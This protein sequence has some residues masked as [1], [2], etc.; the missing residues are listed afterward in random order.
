MEPKAPACPASEKT[1]AKIPA[2]QASGKTKVKSPASRASEEMEARTPASQVSGEMGTNTPA[3]HKSEKRE[4][5]TPVSHT[6]ESDAEPLT[7]FSLKSKKKKKSWKTR[8]RTLTLQEQQVMGRRLSQLP[9]HKL[10]NLNDNKKERKDS[11]RLPPIEIDSLVDRLAT[12][13]KSEAY[14]RR[15]QKENAKYERNRKTSMT[16]EQIESLVE[17]LSRV[18]ERDKGPKEESNGKSLAKEQLDDLIERL[19]K[20]KIPGG[21]KLPPIQETGRFKGNVRKMSQADVE[22][23]IDRVAFKGMKTWN[24]DDRKRSKERMYWGPWES[25]DIRYR[26]WFNQNMDTFNESWQ[27]RI[28]RGHGL[29]Y[30]FCMIDKNITREKF[31]RP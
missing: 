20:P 22:S 21:T 29:S 14:E 11:K 5:R 24:E 3:S 17:R 7:L 8:K 4:A 1:E 10:Q 26:L 9:N 6:S 28:R 30:L 12:S 25:S 13:K 2:S 31:K 16:D 15:I 23:M 19:N 27:T 18:K